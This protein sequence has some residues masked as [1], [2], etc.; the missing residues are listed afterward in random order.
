MRD[1][2]CR[3]VIALGRHQQQRH[4]TVTL[5]GIRVSVQYHVNMSDVE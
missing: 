2:F 1:Q 3:D 4:V 5:E